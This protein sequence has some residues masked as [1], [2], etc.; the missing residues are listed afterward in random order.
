MQLDIFYNTIHLSGKPLA[1][2]R[3]QAGCQNERVVEIVKDLGKATPWKVWEAYKR[4]YPEAPITSLRRSM[5][6]LTKQGRLEKCFE[7]EKERLGQPNH[8]W[9]VK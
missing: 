1:D 9:R 4:L 6:V 7:M 3:A 2:A 5:T 8:Y